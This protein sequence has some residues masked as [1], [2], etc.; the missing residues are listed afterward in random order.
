M[1]WKTSGTI[2][3]ASHHDEQ[4]S[5]GPL[6]AWYHELLVEPAAGL[7]CDWPFAAVQIAYL[8]LLHGAASK[9]KQLQ[10]SAQLRISLT[11]V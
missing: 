5:G 10:A 2:V 9:C 6:W 8:L 7:G 1:P 3:T 11:D 4:Y